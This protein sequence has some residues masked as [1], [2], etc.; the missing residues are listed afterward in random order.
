MND[1][2]EADKDRQIQD[3]RPAFEE[4]LRRRELLAGAA[5]LLGLAMA[6]AAGATPAGTGKKGFPRNFLWGAATAAHQVEGGNVNSDYWL[7]EHMHP[8]LFT[9]PSGDACDHYHR[10]REDIDLLAKMGLNCYRFSIEWARVEPEPGFFSNAEFEHY[11]R[12]LG[13]CHEAGVTPVLTLHHFSSPRWFAAEG[14]WENDG[15][16][17]RFARFSEQ[18]SRR[19]GDLIGAA[20]TINEPNT[21][22]SFPWQG[23]AGLQQQM[24]P[25]LTAAA[26][27]VGSERFS[28]I[29]FGEP[30]ATQRNLIAAHKK[31][32][33]ALKSGRGT[34]PV[35]P[36]LAISDDRPDGNETGGRD[37]KRR[38]VYAPWFDAAAGSDFIGVQT[39]K[40]VAVG[41]T[42]DLPPEAGTELTQMGYAFAPEALEQTIRYAHAATGL[43]ILVTENGVATAD[44]SRRRVFIQRAVEGVQACLADGIDVRGYIHWSLFDNFEWNYGYRPTFGLVA[45]DRQTFA[46]H[47]KPSAYF[48][49]AIARRNGL[50]AI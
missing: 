50:S 23:A 44:D 42:A 14:A 26:H 38:E 6:P 1:L 49:G 40:R 41:R 16:A 18:V 20:V 5:G 39:Y 17:D 47:P 46:R 4:G 28:C 37:R 22:E 2:D 31:S 10:Y 32:L 8:S 21:E 13:R 3:R 27:K 33:E 43:P 29:P 7:L 36:A 24:R 9:E 30:L 34:F 12:M 15:A 19:L 11:R 25:F 45:V 35:G 48:L